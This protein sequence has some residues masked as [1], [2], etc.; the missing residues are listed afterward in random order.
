MVTRRWLKA[1][2]VGEQQ[3]E[4]ALTVGEIV[5]VCNGNDTF[6]QAKK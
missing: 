3:L 5:E 6:I 2:V 4:T 1:A